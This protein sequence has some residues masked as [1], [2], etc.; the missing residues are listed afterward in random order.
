[1]AMDQL[2][3]EEAIEKAEHLKALG[4]TDVHLFD[5]P[6]PWGLVDDR[7]PLRGS[8]HRFD[9]PVDVGFFAN[10]PCGLRFQWFLDLEKRGANGSGHYQI[11]TDGI[12]DA[13][14]RMNQ[15]ARDSFRRYLA[16]LSEK[17]RKK[18]LETQRIADSQF[19]MAGF[20]R[21]ACDD[22]EVER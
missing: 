10:H 4:K 16:G 21:G 20:L 22:K 1:M 6:F 18:G 8:S 13:M 7:S 19:E 9:I 11:D 17:V 2:G 15:G 5:E 12:R 3:L 14:S